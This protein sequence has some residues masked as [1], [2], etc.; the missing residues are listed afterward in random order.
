MVRRKRLFL[1]FTITVTLCYFF[2]VNLGGDREPPEHGLKKYWRY[3]AKV[4]ETTNFI[5]SF[6]PSYQILQTAASSAGLSTMMQ[7]IPTQESKSKP[8]AQKVKKGKRKQPKVSAE[9][10][11]KKM[12][13]TR[14][15]SR[16]QNTIKIVDSADQTTS[17]LSSNFS[18][19]VIAL[20]GHFPSNGF[21]SIPAALSTDNNLSMTSTVSLQTLQQQIQ[22]Q[23]QQTQLQLQIQLLQQQLQNNQNACAVAQTTS[24]RSANEGAT[25]YIVTPTVMEQHSQVQS[26]GTPVV[27]QT[28]ATPQP[29]VIHNVT[30]QTVVQNGVVNTEASVIPTIVAQGANN[31]VNFLT[32]AAGNVSIYQPQSRNGVARTAQNISLVTSPLRNS[33]EI[34][35]LTASQNNNGSI[36]VLNTP[37]QFAETPT[38][39][40]ETYRQV[41]L[42][43]TQ[44]PPTIAISQPVT[45]SLQTSSLPLSTLPTMLLAQTTPSIETQQ[46]S[47]S[48]THPQ[49][50]PQQQQQHHQQLIIQPRTTQTTNEQLVLQRALTT[51]QHQQQQQRQNA[52]QIIVH[53]NIQTNAD[54]SNTLLPPITS[55]NADAFLTNSGVSCSQVGT[56]YA[57]ISNASLADIQP[58]DIIEEQDPSADLHTS[59]L[60]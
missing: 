36:S 55:F 6:V 17:N 4:K 3:N 43:A 22:Q 12:D 2:I 54:Q 30:G 15:A 16:L 7:D 42:I 8:E 53:P 29:S 49:Q 46:L 47:Q 52:N 20:N 56:T 50:Q 21:I 35:I 45:I 44:S 38:N 26:M 19:T 41:H 27:V 59:F 57:V 32:S 23:Q 10:K 13:F 24:L 60:T 37:T 1:L 40:I 25:E 14:A 48:I 18:S 9:M 51:A 34:S 33:G 5:E 39:T 11:G 28:V 31:N 58:R